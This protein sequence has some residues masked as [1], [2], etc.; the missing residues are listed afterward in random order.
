MQRNWIGR[1]KGL[2]LRFDVQGV[3]EPLSVQH[4][5]IDGVSCW[6]LRITVAQQAS[7]DNPE[8]TAFTQSCRTN[9]VSEA[10]LATLEKKAALR[11]FIPNIHCDRELPIWIANF[12]LSD[13]GTGAVMA[14]PAINV[15]MSLPISTIS[16]FIL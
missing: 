5:Y 10:Q 9:K 4:E 16:R 12:V 8:I 14:V 2:S 7:Q 15:T 3:D 13:Y 1:S 6:R 11:V